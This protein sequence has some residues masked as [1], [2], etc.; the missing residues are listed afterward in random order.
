MP[1]VGFHGPQTSGVVWRA[2]HL[3]SPVKYA[4]PVFLDIRT[5]LLDFLET[6]LVTL[7]AFIR[8]QIQRELAEI[9]CFY[10]LSNLLL[11]FALSAPE[12]PDNGLCNV[13]CIQ[14]D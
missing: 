14:P 5:E 12:C 10:R 2:P 7:C 13:V 9:M 11:Y 3:I 1:L 4:V 8:I 6:L